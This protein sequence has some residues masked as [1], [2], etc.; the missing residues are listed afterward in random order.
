MHIK[1]VAYILIIGLVLVGALIYIP[2]TFNTVDA[3]VNN[4][5]S[6]AAWS[7]NVGWLDFEPSI[8]GTKTKTANIDTDGN[9][10]GY[11]WNSNIGWIKMNPPAP[12]PSAPLNSA[13]LVGNDV[14]GWIRACS[15]LSDAVNCSGNLNPDTTKTGGWDGWIKM[16]DSGPG[17][18]ADGVSLGVADP[19]DNNRI[20]DGYAWGDLVMGWIQWGG[21][22][23]GVVCENNC[24]NDGDDDIEVIVQIS[25][26]GSVNYPNGTVCE[27]TDIS[28]NTLKICS[29]YPLVDGQID[30][31]FTAVNTGANPPFGSWVG[32]C[33]FDSNFTN[34]E[35]KVSNLPATADP[36]PKTITAT[37]GTGGQDIDLEITS[38]DPLGRIKLNCQAAPG[39]LTPP[40]YSQINAFVTN[41]TQSEEGGIVTNIPV[42]LSSFELIGDYKVA[43][44]PVA[45]IVVRN[46]NLELWREVWPTANSETL[47]FGGVLEVG[48]SF[49]ARPTSAS[50]GDMK[51]T[52]AIVRFKATG[53]FESGSFNEV[54]DI[55]VIYLDSN[56]Q[57]N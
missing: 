44:E 10:T 4:N 13:K 29:N 17:G 22:I 16:S 20:F 6:G 24:D 23:G 38:T 21:F 27:N 33:D 53:V 41:L 28:V 5:V 26:L 32:D 37:F 45:K 18:W 55:P 3:Q 9:F 19:D 56:F 50:K 57:E 8:N 31:I 42:T 43:G 14:T 30:K 35:C 11:T 51:T 49:N 40:Y 1:Q 12:Y 47:E 34:K 2:Q 54:F 15:V 52:D 48:L 39:C 46:N 7:S 25:G 36:N